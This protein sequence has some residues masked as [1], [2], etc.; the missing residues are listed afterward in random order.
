MTLIKTVYVTSSDRMIVNYELET[1]WK[2]TVIASFGV[3]PCPEE[4]YE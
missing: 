1:L 4:N 2:E 3:L